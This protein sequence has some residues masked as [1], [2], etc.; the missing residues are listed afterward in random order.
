MGPDLSD[1]I[2]K[3]KLARMMGRF[4]KSGV[5]LHC[6]AGKEVNKAF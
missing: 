2:G 3:I 4:E 5:E 1:N 6:V